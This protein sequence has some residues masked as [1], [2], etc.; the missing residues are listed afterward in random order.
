MIRAERG[1]AFVK[2]SVFVFPPGFVVFTRVSSCFAIV[3]FPDNVGISL[4]LSLCVYEL[5]PFKIVE[6]E[7][8]GRLLRELQRFYIRI[9]LIKEEEEEERAQN[10]GVARNGWGSKA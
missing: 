6:G 7:G 2:E 4:S 10:L 3:S 9:C 5:S 8:L 1:R